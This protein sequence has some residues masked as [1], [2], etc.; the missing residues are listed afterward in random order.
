MKTKAAIITAGLVWF[1]TVYLM[2]VS[3]VGTLLTTVA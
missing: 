3:S 1:A 2:I